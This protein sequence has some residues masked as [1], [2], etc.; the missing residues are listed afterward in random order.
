MNILLCGNYGA[1]NEGDEAILA[2][3]IQTL[4]EIDPHCKITAVSGNPLETI[5]RHGIAAV[6]MV[7]SGV[8]SFLKGTNPVTKKVFQECTVVILG[9]GGLLQDEEPRALL[10]WG[11]HAWYARHYKKP[12][13][14]CA[15]TIGP[16]RRW[17]GKKMALKILSWCAGVSV[18]DKES[19]RIWPKAILTTDL[20]FFPQKC[21]ENVYENTEI[22]LNLRPWANLTEKMIKEIAAFCVKI[23]HE[24]KKP[25]ILM[26]FAE[27]KTAE[28]KDAIILEKVAHYAGDAVRQ[29][30]IS[31]ALTF[32]QNAKL[33]I[34]MRLHPLLLAIQKKIPVIA[35][36]YTQKVH[37][38][39]ANCG[40]LEAT[41]DLS[42]MTKEKLIETYKK[43]PTQKVRTKNMHDLVTNGR[44]DLENFLAD[45]SGQATPKVD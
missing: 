27:G 2:A 12:L 35:L 29:V 13:Y 5:Q 34:S 17:W 24:E 16:L 10:I 39:M 3:L 42:D 23:F 11:M 40:L 33:V 45:Y 20:I 9:G 14:A 28:T 43:Y 32:L 19:L 37:G 41:I 30:R 31:E 44:T 26:P 25:I 15:Q 22:V 4:G 8:R 18:R 38:A 6:P 1:G 7:P 36:S 21:T